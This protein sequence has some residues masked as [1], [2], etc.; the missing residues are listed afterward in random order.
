VLQPG[1][2]DDAQWATFE[3]VYEMVEAKEICDVISRQFLR[4]ASLLQKRQI[5]QP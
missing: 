4:Q 3:K 5:A 2:T 1:E